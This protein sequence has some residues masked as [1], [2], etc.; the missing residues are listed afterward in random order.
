MPTWILFTL[1]IS[2][3]IEIS[4]NRKVVAILIIILTIF[5]AFWIYSIAF[6]LCANRI[7]GLLFNIKKFKIILIFASI[8]VI[9]L[10][11]YY[12]HS[13]NKSVDLSSFREL[14]VIFFVIVPGHIFLAYSYF[15]LLRFIS[16]AIS[17]LE[18]DKNVTINSYVGYLILLFFF[19]LGIWW[20]NPKIKSLIEKYS[21]S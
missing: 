19:P 11:L 2:P 7:N 10:C 1:S 16:K 18:N 12:I 13:L 8:Y 6:K 3:L 14:R 20:I 5:F 17:T 9:F 21:N 15:F 4:N